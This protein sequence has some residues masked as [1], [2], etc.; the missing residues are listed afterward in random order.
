MSNLPYPI[1]RGQNLLQLGEFD[2]SE[3][4]ALIRQEQERIYLIGE[5]SYRVR[6]KKPSLHH[7]YDENGVFSG[8]SLRYRCFDRGVSCV[9]CG[10]KGSKLLLEISP[11]ATN[12][13][14]HFNLYA[15]SDRGLV[16]M[17]HDH[18]VPLSKKGKDTIDNTQTMCVACNQFKGKEK[19][20]NEWLLRK[21]VEST[22]PFLQR[23]AI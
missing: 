23:V 2:F 1:L 19:I 4:S 16:L 3:L 17:T 5:I 18:I 21:I 15:E 12:A 20:S 10:A 13:T 7:P 22:H 8:W 14:A 11:T 9:V 6:P